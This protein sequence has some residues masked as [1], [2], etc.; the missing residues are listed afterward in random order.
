MLFPWVN[1]MN[2]TLNWCLTYFMFAV[3]ETSQSV[4]HLSQNNVKSVKYSFA[5]V[6]EFGM[7]E[8]AL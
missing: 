3:E 6:T 8:A 5:K 2:V 7:V 4:C 1:G